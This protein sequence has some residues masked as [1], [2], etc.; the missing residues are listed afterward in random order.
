MFLL[1]NMFQGGVLISKEDLYAAAIAAALVR[2]SACSSRRPRPA[3]RCVAVADD[4]Q[5]AQ[6]I[7]HPLNRIWV[8]VWSVA[9]F[10]RAGWPHHLGQ[11]SWGCSSRS[12][13]W[14]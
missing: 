8:I 9:G 5:A 11:A 7:G 14:R 3:A 4:H 12:R 6:A 1:E 13:W 2:C 10:R